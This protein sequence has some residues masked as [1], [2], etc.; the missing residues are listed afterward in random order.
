[1]TGLFIPASLS[2]VLTISEGG[3]IRQTG[4][5]NIIFLP[6]TLLTSPYSWSVVFLALV[7]VLFISAAFMTYYAYKAADRPAF[8][9]LRRYALFWSGP[10]ILASIWVFMALY[11]HNPTHFYNMLDI[12]WVFL[13]SL[14]CCLGAIYLLWWRKALGCSFILVMLQYAFAFFGYGYSHLP[15][16]LYPYITVQ[17]GLTN[18]TMGWALVIAFIAG[19][20]LL[21]PSL[22]LLLRLF[23]FS[24]RYV[25]GEK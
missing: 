22:F 1:M 11:Q 12:A 14:V 25:R 23:L 24:A 16:L 8:E 18:S 17:S 6:E 7:S 9:I 20:F 3:F 10:T 5:G 21:I 4:D 2:T 13:F 19:L 15:Y